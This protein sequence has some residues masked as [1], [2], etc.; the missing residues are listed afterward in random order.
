MNVEAIATIHNA[1]VD[2]F[3]IPRQS[4][5]AESDVSYIVFKEKY[6]NPEALR[7]IEGYSHLWLLWHF[8][9]M[10]AKRDFSPTV[11]PPRLGGNTRVGVFA[12]RSPNRPNSIGMSSVKLGRVIKTEK[13]GHV[14]EVFGADILSGTDVFDVKPYVPYSDSHPDAVGGFAVDGDSYS[15][16]LDLPHELKAKVDGRD[17][18]ALS[19]ILRGDPRPSYQRDSERIYTLDYYRYKVSFRVADST[20]H[21]VSIDTSET[22]DEIYEYLRMC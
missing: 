17:I 20:V 22:G 12:T 7:G 2:K 3:G 16:S 14:L 21:V 1:H 8:S 15:L 19:D 10:E 4:G 9:E 18:E 5:L 11:R 13:Y 6:R